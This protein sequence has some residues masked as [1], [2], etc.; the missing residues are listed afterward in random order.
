MMYI[1]TSKNPREAVD[2]L[3]KNT[4][5]NFC[6]KQLIELSQ[7]IS[8]S[9]ISNQMKRI[10]QGKELQEWIKDNPY[11]THNFYLSLCAYCIENIKMKLETI[12]KLVNINSDLL[13]YTIKKHATDKLTHAYFRYNKNYKSEYKTKSLLP[14]EIACKEYKKYI[15]TFKFPHQ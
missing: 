5:K 15:E 14:V 13:N 4:N 12:V 8:S 10:P 9:G 7:L 11:Y 2:Y 3:I 6:F 1:I